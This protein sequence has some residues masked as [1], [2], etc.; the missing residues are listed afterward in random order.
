[1][2]QLLF[3]DVGV[4]VES[5]LLAD[6]YDV[7]I[8]L[9]IILQCMIG[10]FLG[11]VFFDDSITKTIRKGLCIHSIGHRSRAYREAK[12]VCFLFGEAKKTL[13][14][15]RSCEMALEGHGVF[16]VFCFFFGIHDTFGFSIR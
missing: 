16:Q 8:F 5:S 13:K 15:D 2:C 4:L 12:T 14:S 1:M 9:L 10:C 11:S 3:D 7:L 6:E